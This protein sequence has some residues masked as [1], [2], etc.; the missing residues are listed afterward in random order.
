MRWTV[1]HGI[2]FVP[3]VPHGDISILASNAENWYD[4]DRGDTTPSRDLD[5]RDDAQRRLVLARASEQSLMR[6]VH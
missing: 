2:H 1:G 6:S 4:N 5:G 3:G